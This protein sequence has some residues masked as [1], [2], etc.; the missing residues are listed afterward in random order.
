MAVPRTKR[1][2]TSEY[3]AEAVALALSSDKPIAAVARDLGLGESTLGNWVAKAKEN[4]VVTD[5]PLDMSERA[6]LKRLR[7]ELRVAKME[8]DFLKKATAFFA[9][10]NP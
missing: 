5:K 4:G 6:E 1:V 8:R 10:Q 9:S 2:Y 7:E 3:R